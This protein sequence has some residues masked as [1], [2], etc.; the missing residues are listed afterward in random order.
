M[1]KTHKKMSR[2]T[3]RDGRGNMDLKRLEFCL[4]RMVA[5]TMTRLLLWKE[6]NV[7]NKANGGLMERCKHCIARETTNEVMD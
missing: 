5:N 2:L 6:K 7:N 1:K 3:Q 4:L